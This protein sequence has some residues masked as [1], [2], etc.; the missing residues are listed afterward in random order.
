MTDPTQRRRDANS[1]G[2]TIG[3]DRELPGLSAART[4]VIN[5][6]RLLVSLFRTEIDRFISNP[7]LLD[8]FFRHMF[9][10]LVGADER[11]K[12]VA[13]FVRQQPTCV[14]GYPRTSTQFPCFAIV[15]QEDA[16]V[17]NFLADYVGET[18]DEEEDRDYM[19]YSGTLCSNTYAI[20]VYSQHP[21][22]CLYLYYFAKMIVFGAKPLF[23]ANGLTEVTV[24]GGEV[25]P[26]E[27]YLPDN[28]FLRTLTITGHSMFTVPRFALVDRRKMQLLGL[29][30]NDVVVDGI[31]G[32]IVPEVFN[33]E[34]NEES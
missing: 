7:E 30:R 22:E 6:E 8:R 34:S 28:V 31:Q 13:N 10:P 23:V 27:Q 14:L 15:L 2:G 26:E 29:Y 1:I 25:A 12:F 33:G 9:D 5:I 19:E 4:N 21:D 32:G 20:S 17:Q 16:E 18:E 3:I 24:S 11:D